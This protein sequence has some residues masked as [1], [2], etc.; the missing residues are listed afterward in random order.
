MAWEFYCKRY[1]ILDELV[2]KLVQVTKR[3][4]IRALT[5]VGSAVLVAELAARVG[6]L[7]DFG[8]G[9][10]HYFKNS[11]RFN[12]GTQERIYQKASTFMIDGGMGALRQLRRFGGKSKFAISVSAGAIFGQTV[13]QATTF[14]VRATLVSFFFI[15]TLS[16]LGVIGDVGESI[17]DWVDD[18]R[19]RH[20]GWTM[21]MARFHK[22]AR[23]KMSF[24]WLEELYEA[25]VDEEKIASFGF[26]AGTVFALL[27]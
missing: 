10:S 7:G 6:I 3:H 25:A 16:F 21:K 19:D 23:R 2:V 24:E 15:E 14:A 9:L 26:S 22:S 5:V 13:I 20:A 11:E 18:E 8:T 17:L 12:D 4:S 27:T 1:E